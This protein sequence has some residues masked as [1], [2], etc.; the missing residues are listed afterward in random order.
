MATIHRFW[1]VF[2]SAVGLPTVLPPGPKLSHDTEAVTNSRQGFSIPVLAGE[3]VHLATSL[4]ATGKV[5]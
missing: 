5:A 2:P 1:N 4:S 3:V